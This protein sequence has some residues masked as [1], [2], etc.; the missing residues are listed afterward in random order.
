M[1]NPFFVQKT[2]KL[3]DLLIGHSK[4][5][6]G[7]NIFTVGHGSQGTAYILACTILRSG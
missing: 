3:A 5:R 1:S 2:L 6:C 7:Y 4:F